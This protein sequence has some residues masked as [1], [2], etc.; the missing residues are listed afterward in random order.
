MVR[1]RSESA[2]RRRHDVW[3]NLKWKRFGTHGGA[4]FR[5]ALRVRRNTFLMLV[6]RVGGKSAVD[7]IPT[8]GASDKKRKIWVEPQYPIFA[9]T[10]SQS[11]WFS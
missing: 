2:R 1:E 4:E 3:Q 8:I 6:A 5:S 7:R 9:G 11:R 10:T